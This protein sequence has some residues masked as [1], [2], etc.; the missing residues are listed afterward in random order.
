MKRTLCT[1]LIVVLLIVTNLF[2]AA[3]HSDS[4]ILEDFIV[5]NVEVSHSNITFT[6]GGG[7]DN[8]TYLRIQ[9][10]SPIYNALID[11]TGQP[12]IDGDYPTTVILD[13]GNN[14]SVDWKFDA[15]GYGSLG[16]QYLFNDGN[17]SNKLVVPTTNLEKLGTILLPRNATVTKAT[18][19]V[20]TGTDELTIDPAEGAMKDA[21][22]QWENPDTNY[23]DDENLLF[24]LRK[25][26]AFLEF[27]L[28]PIPFGTTVGTSYLHVYAPFWDTTDTYGVYRVTEQWWENNLTWN[29]RPTVAGTPVDTLNF[30][31]AAG[32]KIFDI[33][34]PMINWTESIWNNY[35]ICLK[36]TTNQTDAYYLKSNDASNFRPK[37]IVNYKRN[38][39]DPAIKIGLDTGTPDWSF[40]NKLTNPTTT[41]DLKTFINSYKNTVTQ[42]TSDKY[43]NEMVEIPI[44]VSASNAGSIIDISDIQIE[45]DHQARVNITTELAAH[46]PDDKFN[47]GDYFDIPLRLQSSTGGKIRL[48]SPYVFYNHRPELISPADPG[49]TE[50]PNLNLPEDYNN[51]K[52]IDLG[53]YFQDD[54]DSNRSLIYQV[55]SNT[56]PS[57]IQAEINPTE[58]YYLSIKSLVE[59]WTGFSKV[60]ISCTDSGGREVV[61]NQF[62]ITL[63]KINDKPK[64]KIQILDVEIN[65]DGV[66]KTIDLDSD[67]YFVDAEGDTIYYDYDIDP[68]D[69]IAG[70]KLEIEIDDENKIIVRGLDN[71]NGNDVPVWIYADDGI[72]VDS[73]PFGDPIIAKYG[74][75]RDYNYQ[76]FLVDILPLNDPPV[77]KKINDTYIDEDVDVDDFINLLDYVQDQEST[78]DQ[79][80]F[81]VDYNENSSEIKVEIDSNKNVDISF[82]KAHFDGQTT[83]RLAAEDNEFEKS[84]ETFNIIV[85]PIN[86]LPTVNIDTHTAGQQVW[87]KFTLGGTAVDVD[88][89]IVSVSIKF[90]NDA[91]WLP[92]MGTGFWNYI[93]DTTKLTIRSS[94]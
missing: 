91:I 65:E 39:I 10:A 52:A 19:E 74:S 57:K 17:T 90:D 37:V 89:S 50:I 70:E 60:T 64:P 21:R 34:E 28:S 84:F 20:S 24:A 86:D 61:S 15:L 40:S 49:I 13:V 18:F 67:D 68:L 22:G 27:D 56:N 92:V 41:S 48:D 59:N 11:I 45:Y 76:E 7:F 88:G 36:E 83:V 80:K 44:Y 94:K 63:D 81:S 66:D 47:F 77:W 2:F 38:P 79:I 75:G 9:K 54:I 33:S 5:N 25:S 72:Y 93:W 8:E 78:Q 58:S 43:G 1:G 85:N 69:V 6:S 31:A 4:I 16:K 55:D 32:W 29:S 71:Y 12:N 35:G 26:R 73:D 53:Y 3:E 51:P 30:N 23:G 14:A 82:A 87:G 42:G 62:T 46:L